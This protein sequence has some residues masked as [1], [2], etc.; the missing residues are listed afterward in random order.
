MW[1]LRSVIRFPNVRNTK[2]A[3]NHRQICEVYGENA[4]QLEDGCDF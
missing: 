3:D 2:S 4:D 1:Q